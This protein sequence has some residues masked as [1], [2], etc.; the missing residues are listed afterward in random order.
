MNRIFKFNW[1]Y[2]LLAVALFAIEVFI[3]KYV[4]DT[5]IRPYGGDFLVVIL[6]YCFVKSFV[7][8]PVL[9]TAIGVLLFSYFIETLQY[10]HFID[11]I[12]LSNN[13]LAR[14][15]IGVSFEWIDI[16]S[17][18]LGVLLV[19]VLENIFR[20]RMRKVK[21]KKQYHTNY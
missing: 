2:F 13:R 20:L 1:I 3:A 7:D 6:I 8:T 15:V 5:I 18:T 14:L 12:G 11:R 4:H 17:Y 21:S 19:L 10:F 9:K 16:V